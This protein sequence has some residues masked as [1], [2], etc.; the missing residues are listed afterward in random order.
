M[1]F[2]E[3]VKKSIRAYYSEMNYEN[4]ETTRGKP[5]KYNKKYFDEKE[6]LLLGDTE[7]EDGEEEI[8]DGE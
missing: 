2:E 4:Y 6:K 5:V 1:T 8:V 3:A 7:V